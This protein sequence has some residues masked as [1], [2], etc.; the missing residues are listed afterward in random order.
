MNL[1]E[2]HDAGMRYLVEAG[3]LRRAGRMWVL[4]FFWRRGYDIPLM[5]FAGFWRNA[6][7]IT[8][9]YVPISLVVHWL[10]GFI[11]PDVEGFRSIGVI[12]TCAGAIFCAIAIASYVAYEKR[13]HGIPSWKEFSSSHIL[14]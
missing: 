4:R 14:T 2:K 8:T 5:W 7:L 13:K 1:E 11:W 9:I 3:I 10:F 6:T 12:S